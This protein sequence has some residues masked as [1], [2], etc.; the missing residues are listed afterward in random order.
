MPRGADPQKEQTDP[1][2]AGP[3]EGMGS[4]AITQGQREVGRQGHRQ[5]KMA[6]DK[7]RCCKLGMQ[8]QILPL[9][10]KELAE[11]ILGWGGQIWFDHASE[12]CSG[13]TGL[14]VAGGRRAAKTPEAASVHSPLLK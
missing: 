2:H 10:G 5:Q 13:D 4:A 3:E 11:M 1:S 12:P 14:V 9:W 6:Q 8:G 7:P